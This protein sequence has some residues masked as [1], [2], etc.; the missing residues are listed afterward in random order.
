MAFGLEVASVVPTGRT[1]RIS[2]RGQITI[3]K[4]LR[5]RHGLHP[6]TVVEVVPTENS[7]LIGKDTAAQH[8]V[9][10]VYGILGGTGFDVDEYIKEIRG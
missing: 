7:L 6:G 2:K 3:P 9:D 4:P 10:R 5:N 1:M 8:P